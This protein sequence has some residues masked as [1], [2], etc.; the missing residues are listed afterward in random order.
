[1]SRRLSA[2]P[3]CSLH[4]SR[5]HFL[6]SLPLPTA[7]YNL[8]WAH[9]AL[10][11]LLTET[12]RNL[13][14]SFVL[15]H[16]LLHVFVGNIPLAIMCFLMLLIPL[17]LWRWIFHVLPLPL[18]YHSVVS[19]GGFSLR[20]CWVSAPDSSLSIGHSV[21]FCL[22]YALTPE[23]PALTSCRVPDPH[24]IS[25]CRVNQNFPSAGAKRA[26]FPST[27]AP[28]PVLYSQFCHYP[29]SRLDSDPQ[30]SSWCQPRLA[31]KS[32]QS[33]ALW[34]FYLS[35]FL[36]LHPTFTFLVLQPHKAPFL[37]YLYLGKCLLSIF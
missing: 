8:V 34:I 3:S 12:T 24:L 14:D 32:C 1:M 20:V 26:I 4:F 2:S 35:H 10:L 37:F 13:S 27:P 19:F 18:E 29:L 36:A 7:F 21:P 16:T 11:K 22:P 5:L 25:V 15:T 23:S 33:L 31:F 17:N 30:E 9:T 28:L 6:L